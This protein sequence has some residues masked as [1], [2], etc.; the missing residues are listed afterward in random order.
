[1]TVASV[2][3]AVTAY[4]DYITGQEI[5]LTIFYLI[6]VAIAIWYTELFYGL[7]IAGVASVLW[8]C[9]EKISPV[10]Y[11]KI[12][13]LYWDTFVLFM[14]LVIFAFLLDAIKRLMEKEKLTARTD[15]LTGLANRRYFMEVLE[16]EMNRSLRGDIY[17]TLAYFD[18]DNFKHINDSMGHYAGDMVLQITGG[19]LK[20]HT[21]KMDHIA[22]LGGD[23]F[24]VLFPQLSFKDAGLILEKLKEN[25]DNCMKKNGYAVTFSIG[26]VVFTKMPGTADDA[27]G[28]ADKLMYDVKKENKNSMKITTY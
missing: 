15:Y 5:V 25:L 1:M 12:T 17:F 14:F 16:S 8:Y 28:L 4:I 6:P 19:V 20:E 22:R 24:A 13:I 3:L 23:E 9:V 10:Q 11:S 2:I 18:C 21:R 7:M 27:I 26:A